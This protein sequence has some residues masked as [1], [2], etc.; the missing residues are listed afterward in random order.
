MVIG[1]NE[2]DREKLIR[3][4]IALQ[5][6][7]EESAF[8]ERNLWAAEKLWEFSQ[9]NPELCW[10][11]ILEI[12]HREPSDKVL[13]SLAAGPLEDLLVTH[14]SEFIEKV[15]RQA[16]QDKRFR[17]LL[18]GVWKNEMSDDVWDRVQAVAQNNQ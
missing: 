2:L 3:A 5:E 9:D 6:V 11:L 16:S 1:V 15:E 7:E 17:G 4:W 12:L 14:G 8:Y 18:S 13:G 10:E